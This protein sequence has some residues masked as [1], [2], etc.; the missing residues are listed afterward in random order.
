LS[1]FVEIRIHGRGGGGVVSAGYI[2]AVAAFYDN[3]FSQAFPM[4]GLERSGSPVTSY[5]RISNKQ[6]DLR[7]Q[8]YDPDYS[9]VLDA[10]LI[11]NV[12]VAAG[13][14]KA[15]IVNSRKP[16]KLEPKTFVA[17]AAKFGDRFG[18]IAMVAA[19]AKCSNIVSQPS[20]LKAVEEI[21][22]RKGKEIVDNNVKIVN[23]VFKE[24]TCPLELKK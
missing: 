14:T 10:T 5:V 13:V 23:D 18:N 9:I 7:S 4:F 21:F 11:G 20:L 19:F 2:L 3:K 17:D 12:D 15:L 22:A 8:I 24:K 6:I 16:V 1:E